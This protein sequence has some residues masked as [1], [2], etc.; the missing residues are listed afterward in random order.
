MPFLAGYITPQDY[1]ALGDGVHDDTTAIQAAINAAG[2]PIFFPPGVYLSG[3]LETR[4]G[5]VFQGSQQSNYSFPTP[6]GQ[7]SVIKLK[8]GVNDHL[9]HGSAGI[10]NVQIHNMG[11]D[12]NKA[13]NSAG[14]LIHLDTASAQDAAWHIVDCY[15]TNAAFDGIQIGSGRQACKI[16]RTWVVQSAH[17]NLTINGSDTGID[18]CMVGLAGSDGIN[19]GGLGWVIHLSDCDIW[20]STNTGI[21]INNGVQMVTVQGC[22][23]D[24]NQK[25]GIYVGD[26]STGVTVVG[27]MLHSNSQATDNTYPNIQMSSSGELTVYATTFGN[28][29]LTNM[30]SH[31]IEIYAGTLH[32]LGNISVTGS[33]RGGYLFNGGG[34]VNDIITGNLSVSGTLTLPTSAAKGKIFTSDASGNGAWQ[35]PGAVSGVDWINVKTY[36]ALGDNSTDDTTALQNAINACPI[37]GTVFFPVGQ[38]RTTSPLTVPPGVMLLG[39]QQ[40]RPR[41]SFMSDPNLG[42]GAYIS[43]RS[44][45]SGVAVLYIP[46]TLAGGW[47]T[48]AQGTIIRGLKLNCSAL[49]NAG[50]VD[51]VRAFGQVQ[52]LILENVSVIGPSGYCFN[53]LNNASV[54]SGPV[55]PFS[56]RVRGCYATGGGTATTLGGYNIYNTTDSTFEDCETIAVG[57]DG[58]TIQGGGNTTFSNCR[59]E[60]NGAGNGFTLTQTAGGTK[61]NANMIGCSTNGNSG[62]G[63]NITNAASINLTACVASGEGATSA[64]FN[65]S[66]TTGVVALNSCESVLGS[67]SQYGLKIGSTLNAVI[68]GGTYYGATAGFNDATGNTNVFI[69]PNVIQLTGSVATP[70]ITVGTG[71]KTTETGIVQ[72]ITTDVALLDQSNTATSSTGFITQ[73]HHTTASNVLKAKILGDASSRIILNIVGQFSAGPGASTQDLQFGR[74]AVGTFSVTDPI[75]A[76]AAA[77]IL[78]GSLD[79]IQTVGLPAARNHNNAIAWTMDPRS[80][81]AGKLPISGTLYLAALYVP[82]TVTATKLMWGINTAGSGATA[83][84]N[85]VGVYNAA[86]TLLQSVNVDARVPSTSLKTETIS[87]ALTPGLYWI[88]YLFNATTTPAIYVGSDLDGNLLNMNE[89]AANLSFATNGTGLTTMPATITPASNAV[90]Q[91]CY[92]GALG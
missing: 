5:T 8:N 56:M 77:T 68:E 54:T 87:V 90:A 49:P 69:S 1:G 3:R 92:F 48:M 67:T 23:I 20:S 73:T 42:D 47:S 55:N 61:C 6:S 72:A 4:I 10:A 71:V 50:G 26:T 64:G 13:N 89:T 81:R 45:F 65:I 78:D 16:Q 46:D 2:S 9:I 91:F 27:S 17:N 30:P 31:N 52:G 51:G 62:H 33:A 37:D 63:F 70:T 36:G 18:T 75:T 15:L 34:T 60:N 28:D 32:E 39:E 21:N 24:R 35:T 80:V 57:G 76:G 41:N 12:G 74:S 7:S 38:Y 82:R 85:F 66:S 88:G 22:G 11:F 83:S 59:S 84:E 43:P 58:W 44:T 14:D 19:I 86:G 29:S 25:H 79:A 40:R 53:F